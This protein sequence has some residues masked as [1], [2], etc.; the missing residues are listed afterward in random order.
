MKDVT[1]GSFV[2]NVRNELVDKNRTLF[3]VGGDQ[4]NYPGEVATTTA[5]MLVAKILFNNVVSTRNAKFMTMDISKFYLMT[6]LT[7]PE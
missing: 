6:P 2:C 7:Q 4:I 1:Y 3:V 5:D